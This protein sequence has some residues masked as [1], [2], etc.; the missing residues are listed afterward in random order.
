MVNLLKGPEIIVV[1]DRALHNI[2][3]A[4]LTDESGKYLSETFRIRL[5]PSLTTLKLI[6]E[7]PADYHCQTGALIVGN[8]DV[9]EVH[10]KGKLTN[11]SRLQFAENEAKIIARKLGVEPLLGQ[12][13]TKQAVLQAMTSAA[14]VHIA[15]HGDAEKG[16][17]AL[18]PS[19]RIPNGIPQE[20]LYLLTMSDISKIKLRA[21][22][23]VLSCCH[24]A[25]GQTKAEGVVGITRAFLGSGARSVLV[26]LWALDDQSTEQ[27]M[28]HFY[29]HLAA[30]ES[31]GE[32]LHEAMKWMRSEGYDVNQWAPFILIGDDVT[33]D[34]GKKGK[35]Y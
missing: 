32:S 11:I 27:F 10:F 2:P 31:A 9:G 6:N 1:P 8:P 22:L 33:F 21:K 30:G 5:A 26:A 17:I 25:R 4:A 13:A 23:V 15:A 28:T 18:A 20:G 16:E 29:D 34:F 7:S 35:A 24:S 19:F 14:L 12:Q 3:F